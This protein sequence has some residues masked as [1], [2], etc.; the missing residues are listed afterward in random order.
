[1]KKI[2]FILIIP[3]VFFGEPGIT[4]G[5][6]TD[7]E[8]FDLELRAG[9]HSG[10]GLYA[11][12][13]VSID[14]AEI[15][16]LISAGY[17]LG[18][19]RRFRAGVGYVAFLEEDFDTGPEVRLRYGIYKGLSMTIYSSY[20]ISSEKMH[21]GAGLSYS[22]FFRDSD[23]DWIPNKIDRCRRTPRGASV[24]KEGCALDSD[25]DGVYDG[26][27]QCP[28][29]PFMAYVDSTGCP[30]DSDQDGIFDGVDRCPDTPADI[31]TDS[32]GCPQDLDGD[33][34]PDYEDI[35]PNTPRKA[36]VDATGCPSD[37]DEDGVLDGIDKCPGTPTGFDVDRFGCPYIMPVDT[38]VITDLFDS[39]LNL[40]GNAVAQVENLSKRIRAYPDRR[41]VLRAYTDS[42]GSPQYNY[43]RASIVLGKVA[44]ILVTRGVPREQFETKSMGEQAP[45]SSNAT[46]A[47][48]QN[49]R[50]L[51]VIAI[52]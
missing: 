9:Y 6:N 2:F 32:V 27:D 48:R 28:D 12:A 34:V 44:E 33:G 21:I 3:I 1:M 35:C 10:C 45:I 52:E 23:R 4:A 42:E 13:G 30:S 25:G 17:L 7:Y 43:N 15:T 40:R 8:V 11:D 24:T 29:T 50:R 22:P 46:T 19:T 5:F 14:T 49:N 41:V 39:G 18:I 31:A 16:P 37:A 20:M 51:E 47:G 38:I 36:W 26:I